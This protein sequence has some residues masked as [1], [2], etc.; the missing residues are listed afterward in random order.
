MNSIPIYYEDTYR[1]S[2]QALVES[3]GTDDKGYYIILDRTLFYPQG[4][5][6]PAD[7]GYLIIDEL[8]ISIHSVRMCDQEIRHYTD[9]EFP[10]IIGRNCLLQVDPERRILNARLHTAGHLIGNIIESTYT[11][12]QAIKGHH[13]PGE[14]YVEFVVKSN[15]ECQE[16]DMVLL[17]QKVKEFIS[18]NLKISKMTVAGD[19]LPVLF[20]SLSYSI[21]PGQLVRL[22]KIGSFDYSPCGGT[23]VN[24]LSELNGLQIIKSKIKGSSIKL[25]YSM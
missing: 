4:G 6:Q 9:K 25:N 7:Q 10:P 5:G 24:S 8:Q 23:H 2:D 21:P 22:V 11:C 15:Y 13:F 17:N 16:I 1:F 19:Q 14:C 20:P 18:Q 12:F 3:L